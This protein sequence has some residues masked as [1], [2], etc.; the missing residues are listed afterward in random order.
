MAIMLWLFVNLIGVIAK[1]HLYKELSLPHLFLW[2]QNVLWNFYEMG[3]ANHG[4]GFYG[5]TSINPE[6][7]KQACIEFF[8]TPAA[9]Y[10]ETY[11]ECDPE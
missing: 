1:T 11:T 6:S 5:F 10:Y 7:Q 2:K 9:A 4:A 3:V 8:G